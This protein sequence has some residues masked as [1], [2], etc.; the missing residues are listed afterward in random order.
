MSKSDDADRTSKPHAIGFSNPNIIRYNHDLVKARE[1]M[2]KAGFDIVE[3]TDISTITS[4][5][6]PGF[7]LWLALASVVTLSTAVLLVKK[8][9]K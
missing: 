5:E 8:R 2:A 7:G 6:S 1:Y 9:R 3:A 4:E